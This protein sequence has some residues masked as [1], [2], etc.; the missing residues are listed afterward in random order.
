MKKFV[1]PFFSL[2]LVLTLALYS[3]SS[4]T[5]A[6]GGDPWVTPV[7]GD[8]EFTTTVVPIASLPG[9][10]ELPSQMLAPAGFPEGETQFGGNGV[11]VTDFASGKATVCFSL[12]AQ[13]VAKGWGGK[14]GMWDGAK[15]VLL[16]TTIAAVVEEASTTSACAGITGNGTYAF[17]KYI[18]DASLLPQGPPACGVM[19]FAFPYE[20][21]FDDYEGYMEVGIVIHDSLIPEGTPI[22]YQL[23]NIVPSGFFTSGLSGSGFVV[24]SFS[25]GPGFY[26]AFVEFDPTVIFEYDY[27]DNLVSFTLRVFLPQ[28]YTD[29]Q[30]PE[31]LFSL[32][33]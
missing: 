18:A 21:Y 1:L 24:D 26:V 11:R 32:E 31:D 25:V 2:L 8:M 7:S 12:S 33:N 27:F 14:V 4:V 29:F 28:C 13:E 5:A 15:W 30:Y 9:V 16:P 17:I 20:Y 10:V 19:T 23:L 6:A 22:G 3:F